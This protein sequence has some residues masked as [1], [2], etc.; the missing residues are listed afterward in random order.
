MFIKNVLNILFTTFDYSKNLIF[1]NFSQIRNHHAGKDGPEE[2]SSIQPWIH[3]INV[4]SWH[5]NHVCHLPVPILHL[6]VVKQQPISCSN[7]LQSLP[8]TDLSFLQSTFNSST[9]SPII[10]PTTFRPFIQINCNKINPPA[11]YAAWRKK[12]PVITYCT[13]L[14]PKKNDRRMIQFMRK[15]SCLLC[16]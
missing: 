8:L 10:I 5:N 9:P 13:A 6:G 12:D 14:G 16:A 11:K 3:S 4:T 2:K 1:L 15:I 7:Y